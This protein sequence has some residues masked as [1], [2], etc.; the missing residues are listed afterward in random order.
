M[1]KL[2]FNG[3]LADEMGL[4]KTIQAIAFFG[5]LSQYEGVNGP[6]LVVCPNTV[7][8]NWKKE[9]KKWLPDLKVVKLIARKEHRF[10][11]IDQYIKTR[12]FD[13]IVTS[14][15]GINICLK[16]LKR[17]QWKYLIVDEAHRLKND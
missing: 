1:S 15:E 6:F 5:Y 4:G 16:D 3:I 17:I 7:V 12:N 10:D 13:V 9:L 2:G 11:I 14:Y 8:S